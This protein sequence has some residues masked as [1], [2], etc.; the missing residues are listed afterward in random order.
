MYF[1]QLRGFGLSGLF[2]LDPVVFLG[3]PIPHPN[4]T[5]IQAYSLAAQVVGDTPAVK[6]AHRDGEVGFRVLLFL[7]LRFYAVRKPNLP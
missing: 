5:V 2:D 1:L 4:L 3:S 7:G 6:G